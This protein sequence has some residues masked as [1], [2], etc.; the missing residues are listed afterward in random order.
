MDE[1]EQRLVS[2]LD[3]AVPEPRNNIAIDDI[4]EL[5]Y[6]RHASV[7]QRV[8]KA[9]RRR[10]RSHTPFT[11]RKRRL[12]ITGAVVAAALVAVGSYAL[13]RDSGRPKAGTPVGQ[14]PPSVGASPATTDPAA[15]TST[16]WRLARIVR[17]GTVPEPASA[18][19]F[20]TFTQNGATDHVGGGASAHVGPGRITFGHWTNDLLLHGA[21]HLDIAQA[22]FVYALM[23]GPLSW[24]ITRD[25]LTLDR[26]DLGSLIFQRADYDPNNPPQYGFVEGQFMAVG[27]PAAAASP[28]PI[29]GIGTVTFTDTGTGETQTID[30]S[31]DGAYGTAIA[32][33]TYTVAGRISTYQSGHAPCA[34]DAPVVVRLHRTAHVDVYCQEK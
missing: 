31:T 17:L 32:A 8:R 7:R 26:S 6:P 34:A 11:H 1:F 10:A 16:S 18:P 25:E 29:S 22:N 28:R 13:S 2:L 20:F 19:V 33:G 3:D 21:P 27:G 15:L 14:S 24:S 23:E 4:R 30:T 12:A 5:T 9:A